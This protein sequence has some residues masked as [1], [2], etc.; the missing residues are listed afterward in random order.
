MNRIIKNFNW[1]SWIIILIALVFGTFYVFVAGYVVILI[2]NFAD[3]IAG[4]KEPDWLVPD[5]NNKIQAVINLSAVSLSLIFVSFFIKI[6]S[7]IMLLKQT[8]I[9]SNLFKNQIY[10]KINSLSLEQFSKYKR[11]SLINRINVDYSKLEDAALKVFV[12]MIENVFEVFIYIG[13]SI[14]LSPYLSLIYLIFIPIITTLIVVGAKKTEKNYKQS[15]ESLDNLNQ[16]IRENIVGIKVVRIFN[17]EQFQ[18]QRYDLHH[19]NWFKSILKADLFLTTMWQLIFLSINIFITLV[20]TLSG[21]LNKVNSNLSPGTVI[22]FLNYL[23]FTSYVVIGLADY[24]LKIIKT[25][26]IN[27]RF[28]QIFSLKNDDVSEDK[29]TNPIKGKIEF[30]NLN[31]KYDQNN[32]NVLNNINLTINSGENIGII[33]SI[34]S[35]KSTLVG[36]LSGLK[37]ADNNSIYLDDVDI[38]DYNINHVRKN[39]SYDFQ[40]KLLFS[41]SIKSNILKANANA[42]DQQLQD[43]I[44]YSCSNDFINNFKDKENHILTEFGNNLSGGQKA[45][46]CISRT[47]IKDSRIMIFD[48]SLTALDNITAKKVLTNILDNY[49]E[50]TKIFIS[51]QIRIIKD[52][53]KIIVLDKGNVVGFDT[54]KNLLNNCQIYREIYESQKKIGDD[55]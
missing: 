11:S 54:H 19:K 21:Y 29:N 27:K 45:R 13:F 2:K 31:Y 38:N 35:G 47:L 3:L 34:G 53:D 9:A 52:L 42:T 39:V 32:F 49:Q 41:G 15:Y 55:V 37:K 30:K 23:T 25:K 1:K 46:V 44:K 10:Q 24:A 50:R 26:P 43:V 28:D 33:G 20:L 7:R 17:L 16:V 36:L 22:G 40:K 51:Q 6:I 18:T 5:P 14:A 12:Y 8:L 4:N 48:D